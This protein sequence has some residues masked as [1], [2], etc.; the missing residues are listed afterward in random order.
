MALEMEDA[1]PKVVCHWLHL[2]DHATLD[3]R[4][5]AILVGLFDRIFASHVPVAHPMCFVAFEL[6]GPPKEQTKV[7]VQIQRPGGANL[8]DVG[9]DS[10][11]HDTGRANFILSLPNL[12]LPDFGQYTILISAGPEVLQAQKFSVVRSEQPGH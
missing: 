8:I 5:K 11:F 9:L 6:G 7:R 10:R 1:P 3:A 12:Q 4:G 2:T